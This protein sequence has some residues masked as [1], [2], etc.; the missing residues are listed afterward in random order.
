MQV[1]VGVAEGEDWPTT[2]HRV[3]AFRFA[4]AIVVVGQFRRAQDRRLAILVFKAGNEGRADNLLGRYPID[5]LGEGSHEPGVATGDDVGLEVF[6][7]QVVEHLQHRLEDHFGVRLAGFRMPGLTQPGLGI[8]IERF[9]GHA[10]V[11]RTEDLQQALHAGGGQCL[12]IVFQHGL[13]RL[14]GFPFR[15]LRRGAFDF[16]QGE[17]QLEVHRLLAPQGAVVVEHGNAVLGFDEVLAVLIGDRLHELDDLLF[18][19]TV[20]PGGQWLGCLHQQR[21]AQ[22]QGQQETECAMM[23]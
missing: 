1:A 8:V 21:Q 19:R 16:F 5:L 20:V 17:Q 2:D 11:G 13:E 18:R 4:R 10:G 9:G 3:D 23:A 15:V 6:A 14:G 12:V 7:A 22:G